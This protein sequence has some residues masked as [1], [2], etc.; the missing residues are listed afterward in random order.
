[1]HAS[2][3]ASTATTAASAKPIESDKTINKFIA[4]I[5]LKTAYRRIC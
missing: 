3:R 4:Y 2:L 1:V 5:L